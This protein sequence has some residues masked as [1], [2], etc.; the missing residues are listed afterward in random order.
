MIKWGVAAGTHD[1]SL[2]VVKDNEI[3]FA[4]H[5]ERYSR[6]KNDANLN[7]EMIEQALSYGQPDIIHWYED[8]YKKALRKYKAGQ[9]NKWMNPRKYLS[10]YG[11]Q[12]EIKYGNHHESHAAAGFATSKF[13]SACRSCY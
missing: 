3:L 4:S 7:Q 1:G 2:A 9:P 13:D 6:K 8:P 11:I 5:T 10:E 12:G